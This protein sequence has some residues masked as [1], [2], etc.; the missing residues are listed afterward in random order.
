MAAQSR[1]QRGELHTIRLAQRFATDVVLLDEQPAVELARALG[2]PVLRTGA[3]Y[4]T[5]KRAGLVSSVRVRLDAL[6]ATGFWLRDRDYEMILRAAD[7]I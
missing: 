5:A 3:L 4:V 2:L 6:R 7:E 1:L